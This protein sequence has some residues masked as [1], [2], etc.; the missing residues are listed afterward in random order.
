MSYDSLVW[1]NVDEDQCEHH[2]LYW[3]PN[4]HKRLYKSHVIANSSLCTTTELSLLLTSCHTV[5]KNHIIK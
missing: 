1:C 2:T 5:I 4:L 3:L